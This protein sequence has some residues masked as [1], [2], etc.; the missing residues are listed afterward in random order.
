[1]LPQTNGNYVDQPACQN[2][3]LCPKIVVNIRQVEVFTI[4]SLLCRVTFEAFVTVFTNSHTC[5]E[6]G[7]V[8]IH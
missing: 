8:Y 5:K 7:K 1:M 2:C 4:I 6:K 3:C